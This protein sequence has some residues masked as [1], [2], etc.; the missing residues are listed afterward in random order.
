MEAGFPSTKVSPRCVS[1]WLD[2]LLLHRRKKV[3]VGKRVGEWVYELAHDDAACRGI[4]GRG[5]PRL[6]SWP[7]S[8]CLG[9]HRRRCGR[10]SRSLVLLHT[11]RKGDS[12]KLPANG[13]GTYVSRWEKGCRESHYASSNGP[14]P[15]KRHSFCRFQNLRQRSMGRGNWPE[16]SAE[17]VAKFPGRLLCGKRMGNW[18]VLPE[19]TSG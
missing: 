7:R 8:E 14:H 19:R 13:C 16:T 11:V 6:V 9:A 3:T 5:C 17:R 4:P 2:M 10:R 18:Y 1:L 12:G 15:K